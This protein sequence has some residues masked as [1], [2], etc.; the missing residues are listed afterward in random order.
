MYNILT[1][2]K[3]AA[4]GLEQLDSAKYTVTD[5]VN[6]ASVDG[7]IL[8]S[9]S[10]HDMELP[11]DLKAVARAGAGTNNIPIDKCTEK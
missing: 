11:A 10:M 3:I 5:D 8:R 9:F 1:L 6:T 2:N 7:I 4:C